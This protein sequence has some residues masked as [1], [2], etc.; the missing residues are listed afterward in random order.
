MTGGNCNLYD[1][2]ELRQ[3][4]FVIIEKGTHLI[5]QRHIYHGTTKKLQPAL[6]LSFVIKV[7]Y[8]LD[9]GCQ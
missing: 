8:P 9:S 6:K 2:V 5:T 4:R 1:H 3:T 7:L